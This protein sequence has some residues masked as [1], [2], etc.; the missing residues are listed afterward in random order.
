MKFENQPD[1]A[2]RFI[3]MAVERDMLSATQAAELLQTSIERSTAP[4]ILAMETELLDPVQIDI[5]EVML[6]P[7]NVAPGFEVLDVVGHGGLGVVYRATQTQLNRIVA[8]KTIPV[9][10]M[11]GSGVV[12]RFQQEAFAVGRL[13]HPNIVAAH[14]FGTHGER[15]YLAMELIEGEDVESLIQDSGPISESMGWALARQVAAGLAH[16]QELGIVHRDIKPANLL[17]TKPP[18]GFAMAENV[19]LVKITDFGLAKL[20]VEQGGKT[21]LTVVGTAMGTPF[22]MAPEQVSDSDVDHRADIYALGVSMF[23]MLTGMPPYQGM[24][25]GQIVVAK[26]TGDSSWLDDLTTHCSVESMRLLKLMVA[27]DPAERIPDYSALIAAIDNLPTLSKVSAQVL[28]KCETSTPTETQAITI[29]EF[30]KP[31]LENKLR[32]PWLV[33]SLVIGCFIAVISLGWFIFKPSGAPKVERV[34][35]FVATGWEEPLFDGTST[36]GWTAIQG[37]FWFEEVDSEGASVLQAT[38]RKPAVRP[39][40]MPNPD[41]SSKNQLLNYRI[42]LLVDL[43]EADSAEVHF[44]RGDGQDGSQRNVLRVARDGIALGVKGS[45]KGELESDVRIPFPH[46]FTSKTNDGQPKYNQ[47]QIERQEEFWFAYFNE[48]LLGWIPVNNDD[49]LKDIQLLVD[50][51]TVNFADLSVAELKPPEPQ[52]TDSRN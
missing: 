36:D 9:S 2:S 52:S 11:S 27:S 41:E 6:D 42:R 47:I 5:L 30:Q 32:S 33:R 40:P 8:L 44:D 14:D 22:Y 13:Q 31:L 23:H 51:G 34:P 26:V 24:T 38:G 7:T 3:D 15:I 19:P 29:G 49:S 28:S 21:R 1:K 39:L 18:A 46:D 17:L 20:A 4:K 10:K 25:I 43:L 45:L 12:A 16:A 35:T 37:G 48:E 50:G